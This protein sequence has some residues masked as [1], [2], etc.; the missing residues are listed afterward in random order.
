MSKVRKGYVAEDKTS[1][2]E[3]NEYTKE[4]QNKISE[5]SEN[6]NLPIFDY[7]PVNRAVLDIPLRVRGKHSFGLLA[8]YE[9]ALTSGA[10]FRTFFE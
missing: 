4:I 8:A 9:G 7:Y 1:L 10:D 6:V 5:T 2:H 3:L